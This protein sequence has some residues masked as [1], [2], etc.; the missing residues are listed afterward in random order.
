MLTQL[1][2][3][4]LTSA[5]LAQA[6]RS[7]TPFDS[8]SF[9]TLTSL[10]HADPTA[11]LPIVLGI[12]TLAN[13]ESSRWFMTEEEKERER[14]VD[15]WTAEK[16]AR[17]H[18]ILQPKKYIQSA[19]RVLSLGR[20]MIGALVP[21][22]SDHVSSLLPIS[23]CRQSVVLYWVTSAAFG[24]VQTWLFDWWDARRKQRPVA[25]PPNPTTSSIR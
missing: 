2:V 6:S 18:L 21:G 1:P 7:P 4:V 5:V 13:V 11:T 17:G 15:Q 22:V 20:I 16:R 23:S 24:L 8:E 19:L 9:L 3:F 14:K 12:V 25:Q 10:A